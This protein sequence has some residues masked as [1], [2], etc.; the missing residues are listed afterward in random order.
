MDMLQATGIVSINRNLGVLILEAKEGCAGEGSHSVARIRDLETAIELRVKRMA[1]R[2]GIRVDQVRVA[3]QVARELILDRCSQCQ[4]R[5]LIPMK[6][7]GTRL[8]AVDGDDDGIKDVECSVCLGSGA[9]RRDYHARTRAAGLNE[10]SK[11]LSE[12][13][14]ALLQSCCDAE[15]S[16]RRAIWKR[17]HN[18]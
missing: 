2:W 7:D 5:G 12:W 4:G 1:R 3:A 11:K 15:L 9:A 14:E 17:L 13:W 16:A 8:I 10:Y 18:I 6:Y